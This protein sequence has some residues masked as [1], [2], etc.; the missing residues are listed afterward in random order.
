MVQF[1]RGIILNGK[2]EIS[3]QVDKG[4]L[5]ILKLPIF[6]ETERK[7]LNLVLPDSKELISDNKAS[8]DEFE[9]EHSTTVLIVE[10]NDSLRNILYHQFKGYKVLMARNGK[11]GIEKAKLKIPNIIISDVM[12]PYKSGYELCEE[13]KTNM[14]TSHIPVVLLTA[15]ADQESKIKGFKSKADA[16]IFKPY[17]LE[18]LQL[19]VKN[20]LESRAKLHEVFKNLIK[21]PTSTNQPKEDQFILELKAL[22]NKNIK[23]ENYGIKE[24]CIDLKISRMQLHNK[25]KALTGL[26]TSNFIFLIRLNKA[27]ELMENTALNINEICHEVGITNRN[28]FSKQFKNEFGVSPSA[29]RKRLYV[30]N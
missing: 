15:K 20:L 22:I 6:R 21:E 26:T 16:Y 19:V 1:C 18:E 27:K 9:T 5:A 10:D 28:Y 3:S 4:T 2:L 17:D 30:N 14:T 23:D 24:I 12:M 29:W 25:L 13:V 8:E 11:E 7:S